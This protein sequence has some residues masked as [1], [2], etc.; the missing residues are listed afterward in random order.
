MEA[1]TSNGREAVCGQ[2]EAVFDS[3]WRTRS[4]PVP[5]CLSIEELLETA[6]EIA[7]HKPDAHPHANVISLSAFRSGS[8]REDHPS[9]G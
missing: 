8:R 5:L 2:A 3:L 4:L 9:T 6:W 1:G 7:Y